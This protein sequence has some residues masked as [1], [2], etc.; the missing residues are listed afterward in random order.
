MKLRFKVSQAECFRRG[1]DAPKSIVTIKVEP[2]R[3]FQEERILIADRLDP[4]TL[5][6]LSNDE[7]LALDQDALGKQ[8][9]RVATCGAVDVFMKELEDGSFAIGFF[10][11]ANAVQ[12][13]SFDKLHFLGFRTRLHVRDLWRQQDLPDISDTAK[14]PLKMTIPANGVQLYKITAVK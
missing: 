7:V 11:R 14:E 5:N 8:A 2:A 9:V 10:N 12:N 1:I 3:L 6:L 4:F 13:L